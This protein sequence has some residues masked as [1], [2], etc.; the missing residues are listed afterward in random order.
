MLAMTVALKYIWS[1]SASLKAL[2]SGNPS[3]PIVNCRLDFDLGLNIARIIV[4]LTTA[5]IFMGL[6]LVS[7]LEFV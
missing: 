1:F 2:S 7:L 6:E 3:G 5:L 4:E